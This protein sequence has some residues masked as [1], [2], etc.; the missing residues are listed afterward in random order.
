MTGGRTN[1]VRLE[2]VMSSRG[3]VYRRCGCRDV[4]T[5]KQLGSR[6]PAL[7]DPGHGSWYLAVDLPGPADGCLRHRI[8]RGGYPTRTAA[9][10]A[11]A[12]LHH[13]GRSD[14]VG[15]TMNTGAWLHTWLASRISL[16]P[17]SAQ[18]YQVHIRLY[19]DAFLGRI[20][21][22]KLN[23]AQVQEMFT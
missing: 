19:L 10:R 15:P 21:L 14:L 18:G 1:R 20:P 12:E 11:L 7:V 9:V 17:I 13:A 23:R 8:R 22:R 4:A 2:I 16:A 6:C 5:R 3:S